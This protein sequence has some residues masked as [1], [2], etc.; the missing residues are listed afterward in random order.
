MKLI[1]IPNIRR[2]G[3]FAG[4][5]WLRLHFPMHRVQVLPV[6]GE[7]RSHMHH[8]CKTQNRKNIVTK[9]IKTLTLVHIKL[10]KKCRPQIK[11]FMPF[12][13]SGLTAKRTSLIQRAGTK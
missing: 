4:G 3:D 13:Y 8:D 10:K 2:I 1:L 9:S 12:W 5:Q 6:V 11:N 7:L